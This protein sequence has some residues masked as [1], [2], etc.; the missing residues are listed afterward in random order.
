MK[1]FALFLMML[2]GVSFLTIGCNKPA[3]T[4]GGDEQPAATDTEATGEGATEEATEQTTEEGAE[5]EAAQEGS[6]G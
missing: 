2:L 4:E 5:G 6:A 3:A 1:K